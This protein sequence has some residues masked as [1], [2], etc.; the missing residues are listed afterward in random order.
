MAV[1]RVVEWDGKSCGAW[2]NELEGADVVVNL[3]GRSVDCR[4]GKANRQ[5]ILNSRVDSTWAVGEAIAKAKQPPK[6]WL[7]ASTATIYSHRYVDANDEL[8]GI[9]GGDEQTAPASWRFSIEVA[10][11]WEQTAQQFELPQTRLVATSDNPF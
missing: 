7:Q 4:Y 6:V 2:T 11:A 8:T 5:A 9:S 1:A 10:K 3:A